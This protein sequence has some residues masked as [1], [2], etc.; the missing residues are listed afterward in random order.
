MTDETPPLFQY[1]RHTRHKHSEE[2]NP[3][4]R[5][6]K[7]KLSEEDNPP[8]RSRAHFT[9]MLIKGKHTFGSV[10]QVINRHILAQ[11]QHLR[12]HTFHLKAVVIPIRCCNTIHYSTTII[13]TFWHQHKW[14]VMNLSCGDNPSLRSQLKHTQIRWGHVFTTINSLQPYR[15][16]WRALSDC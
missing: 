9:H 11:G 1:T 10:K 8:N 6:P 13:T 3:P 5:H 4:T 16:P 12:L 15:I 2:D 7:H 14:F